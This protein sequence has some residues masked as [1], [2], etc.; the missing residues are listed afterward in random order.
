MIYDAPRR[1]VHLVIDRLGMRFLH[2][3]LAE[4][5]FSWSSSSSAF[6]ALPGFRPSVS[7]RHVEQYLALGTL[8]L[9]AT[10]LDGVELVTPGT[11]LSWDLRAKTLSRHRYWWWDHLRPAASK[12]DEHEAAEELARTL[13]PC[14]GAALSAGRA[15]RRLAERRP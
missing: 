12:V 1:S 2:W 6:L 11:V 4:G 8:L 13:P 7:A 10:W 3:T 5:R 15:G 9:D 14:R